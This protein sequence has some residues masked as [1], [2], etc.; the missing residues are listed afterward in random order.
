MKREPPK[1]IAAV[2]VDGVNMLSQLNTFVHVKS[3]G[4]YRIITTGYRE[5]DLEPVVV[6]RHTDTGNVFVR[7]IHEWVD[8][9][10]VPNKRKIW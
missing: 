5:H 2:F 9:R 7:P 6:Y 8:G 3:G 1:P 4:E 10:F